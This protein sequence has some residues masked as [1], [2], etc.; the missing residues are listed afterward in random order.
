MG[1]V[2]VAALLGGVSLTGV[3]RSTSVSTEADGAK[4][5]PKGCYSGGWVCNTPAVPKS[6]L[7]RKIDDCLARWYAGQDVYQTCFTDDF[8]VTAP[9]LGMRYDRTGAPGRESYLA[10]QRLARYDTWFWTELAIVP[11]KILE[12]RGEF[13][14]AYD[15]LLR[16]PKDAE[17]GADFCETGSEPTCMGYGLPAAKRSETEEFPIW[18]HVETK[19]GKISR[20]SV[21]YDMLGPVGRVARDLEDAKATLSGSAER[22]RGHRDAQ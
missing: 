19:N 13:F 2:V 11:T 9:E 22:M 3:A 12:D 10:G 5:I 6:R 18:F 1:A 7:G 17:K 21:N 20:L 8:T 4:P 16:G 15:F 14:I